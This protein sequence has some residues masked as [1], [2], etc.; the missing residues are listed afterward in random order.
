MSDKPKPMPAPVPRPP[1][2][3]IGDSQDPKIKRK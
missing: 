2:V 3:K 1:L